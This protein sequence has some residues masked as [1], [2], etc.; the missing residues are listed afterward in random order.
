MVKNITVSYGKGRLPTLTLDQEQKLKDMWAHFLNYCGSL[1]PNLKTT[2]ST[3]TQHSADTKQ[4]K[5][6]SSWFGRGKVEVIEDT[7]EMEFAAFKEAIKEL[8]GDQVLKVTLQMVRFD[9]P[10]SL[11]LRFLRA[12]K[13]NVKNA[14]IMIGKTIH[15]RVTE[16]H[17]DKLLQTGEIGAI[18]N[19]YDD[20]MLQL[21]SGKGYIY[22]YDLN[23]R[24]VVHIHSDLHNPKAQ[25]LKSVQDFTI[26]L[27]ETGRLLLKDPVDTATVF[28]DLSKFGLSNM[29]YG[30]VKFLIACFEGY[31][32][33]TLGLMIIHKAPWVFSGIWNIIKNWMDPFVA[34]KIVFT[35]SYEDLLKYF[36]PEYIEKEHG[37]SDDYQYKYIEPPAGESAKINDNATREK[38]FL[39]QEELQ[40]EFIE[41]TI[42]WIKS[43]DKNTNQTSQAR[44]NE[45]SARS[46]DLYWIS[47][48]YVRA[49][50]MIDRTG[51]LES[52]NKLHSTWV[53]SEPK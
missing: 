39:Q 11:M 8:P 4:K 24:P 10:D 32:P 41:A 33:E 25:E 47:D 1:P 45:I 31:Y 46:A 52:F 40:Q 28:F 21:R 6:G 50:S 37:G 19:K 23:G 14:L 16:G 18:E 44:K 27:L 3:L 34:Q 22:G 2:V 12:R 17:P 48:E 7:P 51:V 26:Y 9:H 29:D 42:E 15:W 13:W 30:V 5:N 49:R 35:K 38:I 20:F 53:V 36:P 43:S